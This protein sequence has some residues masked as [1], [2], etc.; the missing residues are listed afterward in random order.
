MVLNNDTRDSFSR[1]LQRVG[2][3]LANKSE[4][5][6]CQECDS[7]LDVLLSPGRGSFL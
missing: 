7:S 6:G 2:A 5:I 3:Y 4:G 1:T